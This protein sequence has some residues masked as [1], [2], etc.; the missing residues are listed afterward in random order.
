MG[1]LILQAT[2]VLRARGGR[3]TAQRR[4]ILRT[5]EELGGHPTAEEVY[6]A[7][8]EQDVTLNPSTVYRTLAWLEEAG[9]VS[10][11][12][13]DAGPDGEHSERYDPAAPIEHHH[14][15]CTGCGRVVEFESPRIA[16]IKAAFA[17]QHGVRVERAALTLYGLCTACQDAS[18]T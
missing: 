12:H 18:K 13:L 7:V 14:F 9:L 5:L 15:V 11:C 17:G 4:T 3:M 2:T 16:E 6:A 1:S 8:H 10:H